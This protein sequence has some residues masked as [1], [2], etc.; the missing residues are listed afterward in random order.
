MSRGDDGGLRGDLKAMAWFAE[1]AG[2]TTHAVA[3]KQA[4]AW[5]LHDMHGNV[6][7]WC[8]DWYADKLPG[9]NV[10]DSKGPA[11]GSV[12]VNRGGSWGSDAAFCRSAYRVWLSPGFR[13]VGLGFRFALSSVP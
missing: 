13:F 6:W 5:G 12:R 3:T 11:S 2:S 4:N 8:A 7:E 10:S 1:N 9:G